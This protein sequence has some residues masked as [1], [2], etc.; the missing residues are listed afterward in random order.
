MCRER[1]RV[2][3]C[4]CREIKR[5]CTEGKRECVERICGKMD[6]PITNILRR[7]MLKILKIIKKMKKIFYVKL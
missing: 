4:V 7:M 2:S 3:V 5:V 6:T 1:E